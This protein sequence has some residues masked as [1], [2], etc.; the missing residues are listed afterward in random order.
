MPPGVPVACMGIGGPGATNAAYFAAR[1][2]AL[3]DSG[4]ADRLKKA[5]AAMREKVLS[6]TLPE[7]SK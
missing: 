6:S 1:I 4:V 7:S 2:I 5:V 3:S